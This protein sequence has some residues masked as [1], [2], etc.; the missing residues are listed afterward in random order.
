[1][2]CANGWACPVCSA[3]IAEKRRGLLEKGLAA[4]LANGGGVYHMLLTV[5]HTRKDKPL[6]LV[7]DLLA[8]FVRLCSGKYAL[9][10]LVPG[11]VGLVRS[12]EVTHGDNGWHPHL[13]VLI[14]TAAPLYRTSFLQTTSG[15]G[16]G[17]FSSLIKQADSGNIQRSALQ[18]RSAP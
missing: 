9:S 5:P 1:M 15:M 6:G 17:V 16:N 12:L 11:Y 7:A 4:H 8:A 13:H 14:F 10:V 2:I 3:K 18:R